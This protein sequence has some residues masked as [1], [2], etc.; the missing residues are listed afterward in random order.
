MRAAWIVAAF[1]L[2]VDAAQ[3]DLVPLPPEGRTPDG[4][5][6]KGPGADPSF[7]VHA[8]DVS[9]EL[10]RETPAAVDGPR[11]APPGRSPVGTEGGAIGEKP[12]R[13]IL[14]LPRKAEGDRKEA[15]GTESGP[16]EAKPRETIRAVVVCSF[17]FECVRAK[18]EEVEAEMAFPLQGLEDPLAPAVDFS[19]T[20]DGK[21]VDTSSRPLRSIQLPC[22]P[23]PRYRGRTWLAHV[24]RG[25]MH[26]C[27]VRYALLLPVRDGEALFTY[28]LRS[29]GCWSRPLGS[30]TVAVRAEKGLRMDPVKAAT[31]QPAVRPDGSLVWSL[32]DVRPTED[33]RIRV[34]R[35]DPR[36]E[37]TPATGAGAVPAATG[38]SAGRAAGGRAA[39]R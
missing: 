5:K 7:V 35:L 33:I 30:E 28:V 32:R 16:A 11:D 13:D 14:V 31:L 24:R 23:S 20:I 39:S 8:I 12:L 6:A 26:T 36:P 18:E 1:T 17:R 4:G 34:R 15:P 3:A 27:R 25:S 10:K 29:G 37:R 19:V 38:S 21:P 9:V 22:D 2:A